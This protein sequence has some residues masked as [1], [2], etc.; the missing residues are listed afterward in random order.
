VPDRVGGESL[1]RRRT[2]LGEVGEQLMPGEGPECADPAQPGACDDGHN[3][4]VL[5]RDIVVNRTPGFRRY[6]GKLG[7][8]RFGR[9]RPLRRSRNPQRNVAVARRGDRVVAAYE[10][11]RGARDQVL[12]TASRDGGRTWTRPV[13]PTGRPAGSTDEWWPAV[14]L[15]P[16]ARVTVAWVDRS[17][18]R[19]RIYFARSAKGGRRFGPPRPLDPATPAA[20]QWKPA[21]AADPKR[22]RVHVAFI[23][24]RERSVAGD[25]PQAH[26]YY[27]RIE[28]GVPSSATRLDT[29]EPTAR[30]RKF[31]NSWA[32]AIASRG[33]RVMAAWTDFLRFD[34]DVFARVSTNGGRSFGPQKDVNDAPETEAPDSPRK[35]SEAFA[36]A[37]RIALARG[38]DLVAWTDWRGRETPF[39]PHGMYDVFISQPGKKNA[40]VDPYGRRQL[41]TFSPD[42]CAVGRRDALVAFQ[43][44]SR[45]QNDIRAVYMR[46]ATKRGRARRVDDAGPRAG[47]AW[48]PRLGCWGDRVIAAW[49]DERDGPAQI[50]FARTSVSRLRR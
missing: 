43:D 45:G 12:I 10:E 4:G 23:D 26:A 18:G 2:R 7:R 48:R 14:A 28:R 32:P 44:A 9:S 46:R 35:L 5:R 11:R 15:G 37:P 50:Y 25:L 40:Q 27:V 39:P 49:E 31:D 42:V 8:T 16:R 33:N 36:D 19:E 30:S 21:L 22:D 13:R 41:S 47:N 20:A 38:R 17:S 3:E 1:E 29:G 6:R 24:E 34:W